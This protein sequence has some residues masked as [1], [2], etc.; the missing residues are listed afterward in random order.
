[1]SGPPACIY[2]GQPGGSREHI[3]PR[4][5]GGA[6]KDDFLCK[7]CNNELGVLYDYLV[8][9]SPIS[10]LRVEHTKAFPVTLGRIHFADWR[11]FKNVGFHILN[12]WKPALV[13]QLHLMDLGDEVRSDF[14]GNHEDFEKLKLV[15]AGEVARKHKG[16]RWV[17]NENWRNISLY[18]H[19]DKELLVHMPPGQ[20]Q[21]RIK[22]LLLNHWQDLLGSA[23]SA[24]ASS[25]PAPVISIR[26]FIDERIERSIATMALHMMAHKWPLDVIRDTSFDSARNYVRYGTHSDQV[27]IQL[28]SDE[29]FRVPD[30]PTG[31]HEILLY[32]WNGVVAEVRLYQTFRWLVSFR[33]AVLPSEIQ[34]QPLSS[35]SFSG[36]RD[37]I[38]DQKGSRSAEDLLERFGPLDLD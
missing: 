35:H 18:N 5:L 15:L 11:G 3:L 9:D 12:A 23:S 13:P 29:G 34:S 19:K 14:L 22:D 38:Y 27:Q 33:G 16:T 26:Q 36:E 10:T 28:I 30:S 24:I 25:E 20:D 31:H 32:P 7:T 4:A 1:M 6:L 2:C 21:G 17:E 8:H 37:G